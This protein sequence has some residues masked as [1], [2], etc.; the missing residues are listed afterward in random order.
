[1]R[2]LDLWLILKQPKQLTHRG[3]GRERNA[4]KVNEP[5]FAQSLLQLADQGLC[6]SVSPHDCIV[7]R[8]A[9][10]LV[11]QD[12]GFTLVGD[13]DCFDAVGVVALRLELLDGAVDA[14]L[15]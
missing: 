6:S 5:V 9:G 1:M 3:I 2:L 7:Q 15:D 11:P 12:R 13:S 8:L 4:A 10:L 14:R